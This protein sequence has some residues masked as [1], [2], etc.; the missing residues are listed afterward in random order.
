MGQLNHLPEIQENIMG[1]G[2]AIDH[3]LVGGIATLLKNM[4]VSWMILPNVWKNNQMFQSP[5]T[6]LT[7]INHY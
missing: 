2:V 6:R 1:G 5:P 7:T 3:R 4:K